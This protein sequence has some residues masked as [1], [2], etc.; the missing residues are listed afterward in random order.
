MGKETEG[1]AMT[2]ILNVKPIPGEPGR[3]LVTSRTLFCADT[4]G[5]RYSYK[6]A[7]DAV[8]KHSDGDPCPRC[9]QTLETTDYLCDLTLFAGLGRCSCRNWETKI[10]P[11]VNTMPPQVLQS[12]REGDGF[13]CDHLKAAMRVFALEQIDN[14]NRATLRQGRREEG[15]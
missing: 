1:K 7:P 13:R 6:P 2:T 12:V 3:L 4:N 10:Q 8:A 11:A 14:L 5:C 15:E 9:G